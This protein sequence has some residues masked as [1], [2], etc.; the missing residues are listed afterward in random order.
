MSSA[1]H[2][3]CS[4]SAV[5]IRATGRFLTRCHESRSTTCGKPVHAIP[6]LLARWRDAGENEIRMHLREYKEKW[7]EP[8]L[9]AAYRDGLTR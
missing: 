2:F 1:E 8:D 9:E 3:V 5:S 4:S 6:D 7:T